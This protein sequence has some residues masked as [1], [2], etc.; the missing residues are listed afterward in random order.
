MDYIIWDFYGDRVGIFIKRS[1]PIVGWPNGVWHYLCL[2]PT[3]TDGVD[4]SKRHD[5]L[6]V[7]FMNCPT[8]GT[9][10]VMPISCII[11]EMDGL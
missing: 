6:G 7:P 4:V 5:P 1:G 2:I 10:V 8:T 3:D 11:G 9:N